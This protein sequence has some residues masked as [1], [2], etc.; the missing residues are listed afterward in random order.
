MALN[1]E[2]FRRVLN[3]V[4][5]GQAPSMYDSNE[6][7]DRDIEEL[8]IADRAALLARSSTVAAQL[9]QLVADLPAH[10]RDV[11]V[12]R[13]PG[14]G[15]MTFPVREVL[16]KRVS[17]VWIHL[18]DLG[19]PAF[20]HHAWPMEFAAGLVSQRAPRHPTWSFVATDADLQW[21]AAGEAEST[22]SGPVADLAR[23]LTGRGTGEG[24]ASTP[25]E[26]PDPPG[27]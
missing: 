18:A 21:G 13:L 27:F 14:G 12:S 26:L 5:R 11:T 4:A 15:G 19:S 10:R 20:S 17:E 1:G 3:Q 9:P 2:A 24:L 16:T 22:I 6:A 25:G 8:A 7:R 23:W